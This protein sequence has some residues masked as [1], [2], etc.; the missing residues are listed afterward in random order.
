MINLFRKNQRILMLIVAILTIIAFIFL[1]N[2]AQL[3]ELASVR[4]PRIYGAA[5]TPVAIDRQ[6]KN[7]QLTVALGQYDLLSRLGG[8]GMDQERSVSEFVWN[9]LVLQHEARALGV[10]PTDDQVA[11]RIKSL[12]VFQTERQ[13]DPRKYGAFVT[14]QLA[15]RGFTERQLEEV[16]R[17]ALRAERVGAIVEAPVA[18]SEGEVRAAARVLQPVTATVIS[19]T[20]KDPLPKAEIPAADISTY[21]ERNAETLKT[22][23]LR[24]ARVVAFELPAGTKPEGKERVEALQKLADVASRFVEALGAN[25]GTFDSAAQSAG[26]AIQT[27]PAFNLSGALASTPPADAEKVAKT[28]KAVAGTAFV[29]PAAGSTS[30]VIES[31]DSF[32]V[33]ELTEIAPSRQLT[34][35]EAAPAIR[36]RLEAVAAERAQQEFANSKLM[37]LREALASGRS[38]TDAATAAGLKTEVLE[39]VVPTAE[40]ISP[41]QRSAIAATLGLIPGQ[42]SPIEMGPEGP[43]TVVLTDRGDLNSEEFEKQR[44]EIV[45]SLLENKRSLLFAEWLRVAREAAK[46]TMPGSR[47]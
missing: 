14:E 13:F 28:A 8:A 16:M 11:D 44:A 2:T 34:L 22:N 46:I 23:E 15:P 4:N 20:S 7:Y 10:Q 17:D 12:P 40:N 25:G 18:V 35:D 32:Y 33:I 21:F 41:A 43:F 30:D 6:V 45:S 31:E 38:A 26:V 3:D 19:L 1:Y 36:A 39:K 9:L 42:L 29:L 24:A 47:G 27:L 5:L 37:T